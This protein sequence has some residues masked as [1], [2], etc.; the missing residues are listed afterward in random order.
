MAG[1]MHAMGTCGTIAISL[2]CVKCGSR[3][4]S[5]LGF[6][7][8]KADF[9]ACE[10]H[11]RRPVCAFAQSDQRLCYSYVSGMYISQCSAMQN[12]NV[13]ASLCC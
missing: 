11:R 1:T 13:L 8:R 12:F 3:F 9:V 10:Q 4:G 5:I 6:D 7:A 2:A